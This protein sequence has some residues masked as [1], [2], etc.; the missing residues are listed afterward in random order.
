MQWYLSPRDGIWDDII[1]S[2]YISDID[3]V[4]LQQETP[5]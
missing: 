1:F 5:E 2:L 3:F 4:L